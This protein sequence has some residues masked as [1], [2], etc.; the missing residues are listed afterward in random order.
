NHDTYRDVHRQAYEEAFRDLP[1]LAAPYK[2]NSGG[3]PP[4]HYSVDVDDV[5]LSLLNIVDQQL[6]KDVASW[7]KD[8]LKSAAGA[9][10]RF[11]FGHVPMHSEMGRSNQE[12]AREL[13]GILT[14]GRVE[15]YVA[16]HEHLIWDEN[17]CFDDQHTI[18]QLIAGTASFGYHR[19]PGAAYN[20]PLSPAIY[21][22]YCGIN[23]DP[24]LCRMPNGGY[25][26]KLM[27]HIRREAKTPAFMS[28]EFGG[29]RYEAHPYWLDPSTQAIAPFGQ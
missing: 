1:Q 19:D 23:G 17:V 29:N 25:L 7:L 2:I 22:R 18:R 8:D 4:Y 27:P 9:R 14:A 28:L 16:G 3:K 11:A 6:P 12:F 20:F 26:F 10:Y 5:H 15:A 21:H 24:L 13:G